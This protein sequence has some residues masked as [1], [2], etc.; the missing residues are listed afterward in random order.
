MVGVDGSSLPANLQPKLVD[1]VWSLVAI[2]HSVYIH[3]RTE[4]NSCNGLP[5]WQYHKHHPY[6]CY[7]NQNIILMKWHYSQLCISTWTAHTRN[8]DNAVEQDLVQV[9]QNIAIYCNRQSFPNCYS[10]TRYTFTPIN[11]ANYRCAFHLSHAVY[12]YHLH[13][14]DGYNRD[15]CTMQVT[16]SGWPVTDIHRCLWTEVFTDSTKE[17]DARKDGEMCSTKTA[18]IHDAR[19]IAHEQSMWRKDWYMSP[20]GIAEALTQVR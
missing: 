13:Y 18:K 20:H 2:C 10:N 11:S 17:V 16:S 1:L 3:Q 8:S 6:Y 9:L 12:I 5:L 4:M 15:N 14:A 19:E 7:H